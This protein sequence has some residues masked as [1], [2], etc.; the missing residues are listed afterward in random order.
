M[1]YWMISMALIAAALGLATVGALAGAAV[2]HPSGPYVHYPRDSP[3]FN[4][5][6]CQPY[7]YPM[8]SMGTSMGMGPGFY[9]WSPMP[10]FQ[11]SMFGY[12]QTP[13]GGPLNLAASEWYFH[14]REYPWVSIG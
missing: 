14:R 2:G 6:N 7:P 12:W 4:P 13:R 3:S 9:P 10:W 8:M 5:Y 11:P 1:H